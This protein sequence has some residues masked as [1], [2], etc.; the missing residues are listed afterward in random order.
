MRESLA[1]QVGSEARVLIDRSAGG[2]SL[3]RLWSQ[4]PEIDGHVRLRAALPP[5]ELVRARIL[6]VRGDA[7]LEA[8]PV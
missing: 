1:A 3:G 4:A 6:A 2:L 7:D 8:E 5:G